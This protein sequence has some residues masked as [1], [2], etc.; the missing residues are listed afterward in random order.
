MTGGG[1]TAAAG[2]QAKKQCTDEFLRVKKLEEE[3][4][5]AEIC[6]KCKNRVRANQYGVDCDGCEK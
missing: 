3:D 4:K 1:G 5:R 2:M 6:E